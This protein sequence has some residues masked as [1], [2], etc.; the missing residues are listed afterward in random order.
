MSLPVAVI[1]PAP[2]YRLGLATVLCKAGFG[3]L[4]EPDD[5]PAWLAAA[6]CKVILMTVRSAS[7]WEPLRR[8]TA[9][10][11]DSIVVALLVDPTPD[12]HAEALRAGAT[13][14]I[15]WDSSPEGILE[16]VTAA[17]RGYTLLPAP[18]ARAIAV[19][20]PSGQ[21]PDWVTPQE[22][23]WLRMLAAG[24]TIQ[25]LAGKAGYSERA[26]YRVL[27]GLYGR[28]RVASRTEAI[29]QASRWGLLEDPLVVAPPGS[30]HSKA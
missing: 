10:G 28:M 4:E 9:A 23:E 19:G 6:G 25:E 14:T 20:K 15:A 26:F 13:A 30:R 8:T 18:V 24:A 22:T 5:L 1:D 27:H 17:V 29:L 16:V 2:S 7:D 21:D 3:P 11:A 12:R